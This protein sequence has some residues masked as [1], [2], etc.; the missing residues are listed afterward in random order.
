MVKDGGK[1]GEEGKMRKKQRH[2]G[3][4]GR[5]NEQRKGCVMEYEGGGRGRERG[6]EGGSEKGRE[7]RGEKGFS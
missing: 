4:E 1:G 6:R 3:K 7:K 5:I 2:K